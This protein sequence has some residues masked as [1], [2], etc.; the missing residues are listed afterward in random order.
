MSYLHDTVQNENVENTKRSLLKD[1]GRFLYQKILTQPCCWMS[2]SPALRHVFFPTH[3][4]A[5]ELGVST[6]LVVAAVE[7]E[8]VYR[9]WRGTL[10]EAHKRSMD[11]GLSFAFML[12]AYGL[13]HAL[14]PHDR[15]AH[16]DD[17]FHEEQIECSTSACNTVT[18]N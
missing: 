16:H 10:S 1:A 2:F 12:T 5:F 13:S 18:F 8:R 15:S 4:P 3:N 11:Y 6:G 14:I 7:G 9:K 17:H